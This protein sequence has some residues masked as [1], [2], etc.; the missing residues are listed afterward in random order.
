MAISLAQICRYPVK[1]LNAEPLERVALSAG[2]ALPNDRR[3]AIAH[4][5]AM[6]D[7]APGAWQPR[8]SFL[9]LAKDEKLAQLRARF[10][11][12]EG[13]LI[14]ERGGKQV[15]CGTVTEPLGRTLINQFFASF[16]S[17]ATRGALY[18]ERRAHGLPLHPNLRRELD[19]IADERGVERLG[20]TS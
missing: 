18:A 8:R 6:A 14:I 10:E 12:E 15:V 9:H 5:S 2:Q 20:A 7:S 4:G 1:G 11:P 3:V 13:R 16:M 17:G 19:A